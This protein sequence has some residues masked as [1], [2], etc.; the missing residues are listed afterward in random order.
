MQRAFECF[1]ETQDRRY[2]E[3]ID[4]DS[5]D[6][7]IPNVKGFVTDLI[8]AT[9]GREIASIYGV[10]CA[11]FLIS[12]VV[13]RD[14]WFTPPDGD[15]WLD[16][17]LLNMYLLFIG[18]AGC[19]KS[20]AITLVQKILTGTMIQLKEEEDGAMNRKDAVIIS[21]MSTPEAFLSTLYQHTRNE[22]GQRKILLGKNPDGTITQIK[23][24]GNGIALV[25]E[26]GS[27][28]GKQNYQTGMNTILLDLYDCP[29]AY[30]WNTVKRGHVTIPE[31]FFNM[32]GG[33]TADSISS[34]VNA[35][36]L[37]DGFMSRTIMAHVPNFPRQRAFRYQT[38]CSSGDLIRRLTWI[39]KTQSGN[40]SLS[41]EAKMFYDQWYE[42]F[43]RKMNKQPD[44]AGYMIRNRTLALKLAVLLK[45]SDYNPG[46]IVHI[47]HLEAAFHIIDQTYMEVADL[48]NYFANARVGGAKKALVAIL[49]SKQGGATRREIANK[50][51][52][53]PAE[54][55]DQAIIELWL[56]GKLIVVNAKGDTKYGDKPQGFPAERYSIPRV[57]HRDEEFDLDGDPQF[58]AQLP[59]RGK[60]AVPEWGIS[61][62][63]SESDEE[64][65]ARDLSSPKREWG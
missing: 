47:E 28:L 6:R 16:K 11:L 17:E 26:F 65:S 29:S 38:A 52:R 58:E 59:K 55:V 46:R 1:D 64:E 23:A 18:P 62:R 60:Q 21:N 53:Y 44:R 39:A 8:Y 41:K 4:E 2:K 7:V 42:D 56:E 9:R 25:S 35:S 48:V 15:P 51:T 54:T 50:A 61:D 14:A 57:R 31:V 27:L 24:T 32:I 37:E 40:Y 43:M 63:D 22:E 45:M 30:R 13:Q 5:T 36:V 34:N 49:T 19:G 10:W 12:S 33:T 20:S 3:W